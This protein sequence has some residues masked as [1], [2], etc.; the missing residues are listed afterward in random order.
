[1]SIDDYVTE[2]GSGPM[3]DAYVRD[4]LPPPGRAVELLL[5]LESPHIEELD[6]GTPVVGGAGKFA[7]EYLLDSPG[8]SLGEYVD[9]KH[10][11]GDYRVAIMNVSNVP[12]QPEAYDNAARPLTPDEWE[13]IRVVRTS[14]AREV[15]GTLTPEA[16]RIG[17]VVFDGLQARVSELTFAPGATVVLCG[18]FVQ[19]FARRLAGLPGTPLKVYHPSRNNWG[20]NP[21]RTEHKALHKLFETSTKRLALP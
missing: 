4:L 15:D 3:K 10:A 17:R 9:A 7:L 5:I 12:L 1:M 20:N 13:V 21:D 18:E 14:P 16:N 2:N 11:A 19:R 6:A 8:G